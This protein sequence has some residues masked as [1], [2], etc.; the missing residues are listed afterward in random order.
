MIT[1]YQKADISFREIKKLDEQGCFSKVY[2]AHD[3]NLDHELVIKEIK[4]E[5]SQDKDLYFAE[6]RLVYK[7]AHPNIVKIQYAAEDGE[8]IYI[9]MPFYR[10]GSLNQKMSIENL[11]PRE[12]IRYAIQ[13]LGGLNHIH[14][15]KLIHFD[16][17]PNN[18]MLS[19][20][21]EAMLADFGL[22]RLADDTNRALPDGYHAY[23]QHTPPERFMSHKDNSYNFTYDIYQVGC[24][25][26]RMCLGV[27]GY[28]KE[29]GIYPKNNDIA[30]AII[31][32]SFPG[33]R[34]PAH[35]PKKLRDL[36]NKCLELNPNDRY[37]STLDILNDL[38]SIKDG[39]Y[40]DW[41]DVSTSDEVL[42]WKRPDKDAIITVEMDTK[43][44][45]VSGKRINSKGK[46]SKISKLCLPKCTEHA[47]YKLLKDN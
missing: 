24:T 37:Q 25:L 7:N 44:T 15:N 42:I 11:T 40:L 26:Y 23:I 1:P 9:A 43:S 22:S 21:N 28:A 33:K 6:A 47:L 30:K 18:I 29:C 13:F 35:I 10:N 36:I 46:V 8:K 4:K 19:N 17:K 38:S 2:L 16:I 14:T 20:R 31:N 41:R 3:E 39:S 34:Y 5:P 12:I 32:G 45:K 27:S